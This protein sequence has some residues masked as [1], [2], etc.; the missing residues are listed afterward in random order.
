M[1]PRPPRLRALP[2]VPGLFLSHLISFGFFFFSLLIQSSKSLISG[3]PRP[4]FHFREKK[5]K[6]IVVLSRQRSALNPPSNTIL[7]SFQ[8]HPPA[9]I[10]QFHL[11]SPS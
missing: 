7:V 2:P 10:H 9:A 1:P 3:A 5:G 8:T 6:K 11:K 4:N